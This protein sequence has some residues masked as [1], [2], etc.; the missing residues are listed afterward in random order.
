M[1][2]QATLLGALLLTGLV[3]NAQVALTGAN[4][5]YSQDFNT[6]TTST[7][8]STFSLANWATAEA[9]TN[10]NTS[11]R[12]GDG[13]SNTG[14]TYSLGTG[15]NTDRALGGVASGSLQT[16][17][18]VSFVNNTGQNITSVN[19]AYVLEQ[20]RR[21][22]AGNGDKD[23]LYF[24]YS[25]NASSLTTGTWTS[26]ASLH[27]TSIN[28]TGAVTPLVLD[29]NNASNRT[30]MSGTISGITITPGS[31][32]WVKWYDPNIIGNDDALAVDDLVM[33]F[34]TGAGGPI[35]TF[36][37]FLPT[38]ATVAEN[39]GSTTL[40]VN[41]APTDAS[42]STFTADVVL[43]S[44]NAADIGNY[45][46]QSV[47]FAPGVST[48]TVP[49]TITD[50]AAID[51]TKTFVFALRNP[52]APLMLA[53]D[54]L[55]TLTV[56]D[57][58][59][60]VPTIP[61]YPIATVRGANGQGQPDSLNKIVRVAG[62]VY[63][64]NLRT[65]GLQFFINDK[66]AGIGVFN[67]SETFGYTVQEGDSIVVTGTVSQF[68]GLAQMSFLDTI[69]NAGTSS[70]PAPTIVTGPLGEATEGELIRINGVNLVNIGDWNT[71][72][73]A[74]FNADV[75]NGNGTYSM[76][77][78]LNTTAF[79]L[80]A[81]N[82]TFDVIGIGSQFAT[83]TTAPFT[84][85]YQIIPRKAGDIILTNSNEEEATKEALRVFPNPTTGSFNMLVY[86]Q[87][88]GEYTMNIVDMTGK[89]IRSK[90]VNL[91]AGN[92]VVAEDMAGVAAGIYHIRVAGAQSS[93]TTP[94][95][96]K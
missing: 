17:F 20:W 16:T 91:T 54:S 69:V 1:K 39:S 82:V 77:I 47:T 49:V 51:G 27:G 90:N 96:I 24:S 36:A 79:S 89:T 71:G 70:V 76:R 44:G 57:D 94:V 60:P 78:E 41:V 8:P 95:V 88:A 64:V 55:F 63:G 5:T 73:G 45:T 53:N 22:N 46:T 80:A 72:G 9:G 31:T 68:R 42:S 13:S 75:Q 35:D 93:F 65:S 85:G 86:V 19:V 12:A 14:D 2:K 4:P 67:P 83:T 32:L 26:V 87:N 84:N 38:L 18:G 92:N 7:T 34:T 74:S 81:P 30:T 23:T 43:K 3:A 48:Q 56:T 50:N 62:T 15:T 21:A 37:R 58:D 11:Y 40:T 6:L 10:A 66:T 28:T 25:T 33:N 61:L 52:S 29:G 59:A